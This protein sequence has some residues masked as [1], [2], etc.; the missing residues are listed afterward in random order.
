MTTNSLIDL[1]DQIQKEIINECIQAAIDTGKPDTYHLAYAK[2][3]EQIASI[4]NLKAKVL[5]GDVSLVKKIR[6]LIMSEVAKPKGRKSKDEKTAGPDKNAA[7][8]ALPK[9]APVDKT[10][11]TN[12]KSEQKVAE[13]P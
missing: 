10:A 4:E 1:L 8:P 5:A 2:H 6:D 3:R 7:A 11:K 12:H 9:K 13:K